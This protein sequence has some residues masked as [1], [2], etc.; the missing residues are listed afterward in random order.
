MAEGPASRVATVGG[1]AQGGVNSDARR[2]QI[3]GFRFG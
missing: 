3:Y 1:A 2:V